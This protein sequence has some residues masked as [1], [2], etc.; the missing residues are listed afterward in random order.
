MGIYCGFDIGQ[1]LN[2]IKRH[3]NEV[4]LTSDITCDDFDWTLYVFDEK[5]GEFEQ[6]GTLFQI[7][8][9]A[10][11]PYLDI[12]KQERKEIS[13]KLDMGF[14]GRESVVSNDN[15]TDDNSKDIP[16]IQNDSEK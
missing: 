3:A 1:M 2:A 10:F 7:V 11:K 16:L 14:V 13:N 9:R 8:T 6:T 15:E 4:S 12:A 5:H